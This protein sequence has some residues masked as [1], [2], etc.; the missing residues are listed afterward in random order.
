MEFYYLYLNLFFG[1]IGDPDEYLLF[2]KDAKVFMQDY[3]ITES[4][5]DKLI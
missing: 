2:K 4:A 5:L 1:P 3:G